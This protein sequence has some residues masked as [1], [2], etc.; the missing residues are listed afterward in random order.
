MQEAL[1][2]GVT[3]KSGWAMIVVLSG[4]ASAPSVRDSHR[5]DLSDPDLP[6][7]RQPY[8]AGF[9][10]ARAAGP[11]LDRLV[12]SVRRFGG[13]SV[14]DAIRRARAAGKEL[15]GIAIVV[16][17]VVDPATLGNSHVRIHALEGQL[18]RGVVVAAARR[19][20]VYPT[21]WRERDLLRTA[22]D[23]LGMSEE[24]IR[25]KLTTLRP[26]GTGA[27]RAEHKFAALAAWLVLAR[28]TGA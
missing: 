28:R 22:E 11:E 21:V 4:P 17:S 10:T 8:H 5:I 9:G 26:P 12:A 16:G 14:A 6:D 15:R 19:A 25:R 3:V 2:I 23:A 13:R 24:S 1:S 20:R 7:A 18:F 27:W